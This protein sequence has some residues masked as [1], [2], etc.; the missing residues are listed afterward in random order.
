MII[1]KSTKKLIWP[2]Y[3]Q[4]YSTNQIIKN[5][6][7]NNSVTLSIPKISNKLQTI[8]I[9][10][11]NVNNVTLLVSNTNNQPLFN[12]KGTI[13]DINKSFVHL[14]KTKDI[15]DEIIKVVIKRLCRIYLKSR[16][17]SE[18]NLR[19][20]L[21]N[22]KINNIPVI[23]L[24]NNDI[25]KQAQ[26]IVNNITKIIGSTNTANLTLISELDDKRYDM[27]LVDRRMLRNDIS[28]FN[29]QILYELNNTQLFDRNILDKMFYYNSFRDKLLMGI[30]FD[31]NYKDNI[32]L[33]DCDRNILN[34]KYKN[35]SFQFTNV[36][37]NFNTF[38]FNIDN[39]SSLEFKQTQTG[40]QLNYINKGRIQK[41]SYLRLKPFLTRFT[42]QMSIDSYDDYLGVLNTDLN[43]LNMISNNK[44]QL[45]NVTTTID[46]LVDFYSDLDDNDRAVGFQLI[47]IL[48]SFK[49]AI[50]KYGSDLL[51]QYL[52]FD[53]KTKIPYLSIN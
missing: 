42:S 38:Q 30:K 25:C 27:M 16:F 26:Q 22:K 36:T 19:Q 24:I 23:Q 53:S 37:D 21:H 39:F 15:D 20:Q 5:K 32:K 46:R 4:W 45:D 12:I 3:H 34:I 8:E 7:K 17:V 6:I 33:V 41:L 50:E 40:I 1:N 49:V 44:F 28:I 10:K 47:Q 14:T 31:R 9:S 51:I 13:D 11:T 2:E 52:L 35:Q 29:Y 43:E 48:K 18:S